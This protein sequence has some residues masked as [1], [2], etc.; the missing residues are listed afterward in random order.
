MNEN[1]YNKNADDFHKDYL[2]K[3]QGFNESF[4]YMREM[5]GLMALM[6]IQK[7]ELVLD[8]G[9]GLGT[10]RDFLDVHTDGRIYAFDVHENYYQGDP[11]FFKNVLHFHLDKIY[12]MHS[13]A[14][15]PDPESVIRNLADK[16]MKNDS[17]IWILTPN[18]NYLDSHKAPKGWKPDPTVVEHF[19]DDTLQE[20]I[21]KAGA[22]TT[23]IHTEP[24]AERIILSAK[25]NPLT[26]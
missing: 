22:E 14:H 11:D 10:M 4:N 25:F 13:I 16:F 2:A 24:D 18:A 20:M 17:E 5:S 21:F 23:T 12:F 3:L 15:I 9:A 6:N 26:S 19:S 7:D 8:Y 1:D